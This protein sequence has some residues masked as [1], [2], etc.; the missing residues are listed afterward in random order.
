MIFGGYSKRVLDTKE[1]T[2]SKKTRSVV[3]V[4]C[5]MLLV[6]ALITFSLT[7]NAAPR[8]PAASSPTPS[9]TEGVGPL[10][11]EE[12]QWADERAALYKVVV[13]FEAAFGTYSYQDTAQSRLARIRPYVT[14]EFIA[15]IRSSLSF[16]GSEYAQAFIENRLSTKAVMDPATGIFGTE[17]GQDTACI[18][19][20]VQVRTVNSSGQE[21]FVVNSEAKRVWIK[22]PDGWRVLHNVGYTESC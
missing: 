8:E 11:S 19:T 15:E 12:Q 4:A 20:V 1:I 3:T 6:I 21:S 22:T 5:L 10:P 16:D 2:V 13:Q 14:D 17:F 18:L 7:N 9:Y